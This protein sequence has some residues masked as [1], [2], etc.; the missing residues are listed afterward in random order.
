MKQYFTLEE[1]NRQLSLIE[2]LLR[3][4]QDLQK[5]INDKHHQLTLAKSALGKIASPESFFAE[6]AAIEF[7]LMEANHFMAKVQEHGAE[8]KNI[9]H[10]LIDF[11]TLVDGE[12]AYLCWKLGEPEIL[13]WHGLNEGFVGRKP[14]SML[15]WDE[16]QS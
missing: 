11:Y 12:E 3:E 8:I 4:L 15:K 5:E 1:A 10:G 6:E 14:I 2:P 7:M 16:S 13:F 9:E